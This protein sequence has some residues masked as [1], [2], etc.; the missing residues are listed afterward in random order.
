MKIRHIKNE[1][2]NL[3]E[4]FIEAFKDSQNIPESIKEISKIVCIK[5]NIIDI[6]APVFLCN[7]IAFGL[8]LKD[9]QCRYNNNDYIIDVTSDNASEDFD[10]LTDRIQSLYEQNIKEDDKL[11]LR[12]ILINGSYVKYKI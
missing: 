12:K 4:F 3:D 7:I 9:R 2:K 5:F 1:T 6:Y 8:G 11:Y 10:R